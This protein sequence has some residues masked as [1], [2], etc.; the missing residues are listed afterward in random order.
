MAFDVFETTIDFILQQ[1][2]F[3]A[4]VTHAPHCLQELLVQ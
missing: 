3:Q 1:A 2:A 4:S